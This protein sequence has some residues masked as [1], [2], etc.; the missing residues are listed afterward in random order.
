VIG[1]APAP[2]EPADSDILDA[3][4]AGRLAIRGGALRVA[5][6]LGGSLAGLGAAALLYRH[7]GLH[8]VGQ[9]GLILALIG[10]VAGFS[11]LGLT[12]VGVRSAS[13]LAPLERTAMLRDL[14]GLR[15]ALTV[16]GIIVIAL[17]CLPVYPSVI[18]AGV[19]IGGVGMV[20][21][22]WLDNYIVSLIVSL[23]MG[24]V[25]AIQ[26]ANNFAAAILTVV[27]VIA[28][29]HLLGFIAIAIPV[30]LGSL[31]LAIR[32]LGSERSLLPSYNAARWRAMFGR[33]IVYSAAV[34]AATLYFYAAIVLT[35]LLASRNQLG[36]FQLSF[37]VTTVLTIVPALLSGSALPIF[38]RAAR[39][40][41][42][43]L[44]Y[45]L[46]RV[47]EVALLLG[48]WVALTLGIGAHF[49][50]EVIGGSTG[51]HNFLPASPVLVYQG[52]AL[53]GT[54]VSSV[55]QYGLLSLALNRRILTINLGG[56]AL[57]LALMCILIPLDGARG[58][59]I[60]TMIGELAA[61]AAAWTALCTAR[62]Q[63]RPS[64]RIIP[65]VALAVAAG[66]TP[67]LIGSLPVAARA[68][69]ASV[70]YAAVV[71]A[72]RS[73]PPELAE[74]LPGPLRRLRHGN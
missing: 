5:G 54:F 71:L 72:T 8:G 32:V 43:R 55:A 29:A 66:C 49:A 51:T 21:Q 1:G 33:S 46:S 3:A 6:Y 57:A 17:I 58:A 61:A 15:V 20:V 24:W 2:P 13:T 34:A 11:D 47:F 70:I 42:Q 7:L 37:R 26:F 40:D 50:V 25:A 41:T 44:G 59:A 73:F 52:I 53:A 36:Y 22:V 68:V 9:Y 35:S 69:L 10:I 14:L 12:V 62:P 56:L 63:L 23:R 48:A 67:L 39:D 74:I 30:A 4:S 64:L 19:A 18:A 31:A 27:L 28:G 16:A 38:A 65:G 45:A 60:A